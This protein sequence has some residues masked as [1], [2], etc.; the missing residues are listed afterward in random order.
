[1]SS[2][3][4]RREVCYKFTDVSEM[5]AASNI[6]ALIMEAASAFEPHY[7]SLLSASKFT[8]LMMDA[9]IFP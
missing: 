2:G 4:W 1:M 6:I 5:L 8:A 7:K 9:E 3:L